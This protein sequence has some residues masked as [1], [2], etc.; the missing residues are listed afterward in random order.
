[1]T[2]GSYVT[3]KRDTYNTLMITNWTM[4]KNFTS[5]WVQL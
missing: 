1:M 4:Y 3:R 5:G 2:K